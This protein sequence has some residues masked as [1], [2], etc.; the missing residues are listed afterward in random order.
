MRALVIDT[1]LAASTAALVVGGK[2]EAAANRLVGRGHAESL[3]LQLAALLAHRPQVDRVAVCVGPGSF[4]GLRI[5]LAAAKALGLAW[6]VPVAGASALSATL[7]AAQRFREG[8]MLVVHDAGRGM[9]YARR[10]NE[11]ALLHL[12]H[13]ELAA[14]AL[15]EGRRLAGSAVAAMVAAQ[16]GL[17]SLALAV[18]PFPD[19]PD[20]FAVAHLDA[21][22]LYP[23][24]SAW[25]SA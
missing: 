24:T 9:A 18:P 11:D 15:D 2:L 21:R 4:T 12:S 13:A 1:A 3:P 16:P 19:A 23:E 10:D 6:G 22:P 20:L 5:G 14:L 8:P 17:A 25:T 7:H